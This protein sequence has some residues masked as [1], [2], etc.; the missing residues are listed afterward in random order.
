MRRRHRCIALDT[1]VHMRHSHSND[2]TKSRCLQINL[3]RGR[4]LPLDFVSRTFTCDFSSIDSLISSWLAI[5]FLLFFCQLYLLSSFKMKWLPLLFTSCAVLVWFFIVQV[6][7][8]AGPVHQSVYGKGEHI[9]GISP[10]GAVE[11]VYSNAF[12]TNEWECTRCTLTRLIGCIRGRCFYR[13]YRRCNDGNGTVIN[14][15]V[16]FVLPGY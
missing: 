1:R 9:S 10:L 8:D 4:W 2:K 3:M 13:C 16:K 14:E 15:A 7:T 6:S 5:S 12:T 11:T